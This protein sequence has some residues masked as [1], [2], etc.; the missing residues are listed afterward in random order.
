MGH[1]QEA[2][3]TTREEARPEVKVMSILRQVEGLRTGLDYHLARHNVLVSNLAQVDTPGYRPQD[4]ERTDFRSQMNVA[5][6]ATHAG[7]LPVGHGNPSFRVI[8]DPTA[9]AAGDGNAVDGDRE[10]VKVASNQMRYDVIAQLASSE[11][12]SLAWA[13]TDGRGG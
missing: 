10:A 9:S 1:R 7:H 11:L 6:T 8:D 4:V 3:G 2:G 12:A 13:A 5:M